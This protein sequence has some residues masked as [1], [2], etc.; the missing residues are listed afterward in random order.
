MSQ[1]EAE[2]ARTTF[3]EG[4]LA[5]L[6]DFPRGT[7][8]LGLEQLEVCCGRHTVSQPKLKSSEESGVEMIA[9]SSDIPKCRPEDREQTE[10]RFKGK[11]W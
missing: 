4:Q 6:S 5:W 3:G 1:L 2:G 11:C 9:S 7:A 8:L 10:R